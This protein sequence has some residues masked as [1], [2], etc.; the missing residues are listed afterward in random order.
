MELV[1]EPAGV[2]NGLSVLVPPPQGGRRSL[3]VRT[4]SAFPPGS[5]L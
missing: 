4:G 3:A 2:A 1:V 5:A